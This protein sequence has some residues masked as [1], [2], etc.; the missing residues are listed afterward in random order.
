MSPEALQALA[1]SFLQHGFVV[2]HDALSP[3]ELRVVRHECDAVTARYAAIAGHPLS[4]D[5][6][7]DDEDCE[8]N[9]THEHHGSMEW[10]ST[11]FGCVLEVPGC[12]ECCVDDWDATS[13]GYRRKTCLVTGGAPPATTRKDDAPKNTELKNKP[14]VDEML[15]PNGAL[16]AIATAMLHTFCARQQTLH[17]NPEQHHT[18]SK[19]NQNQN[20]H[21]CLFNDQYIVKPPNSLTARFGWHADSQWCDGSATKRKRADHEIELEIEL[22]MENEI[23]LEIE[24]ENENVTAPYVS[25]WTAL[26]DVD[27]SN[28]CLRVLPYPAFGKEA[29]LNGSTEPGEDGLDGETGSTPGGGAKRYASHEAR[30]SLYRQ[31]PAQLD[32]LSI[33]RWCG[34]STGKQVTLATKAL[35][36]VQVIAMKAGAIL[37]MS[38]RVLHCSGPNAS[39]TLRRAW[40]PQ[41]SRGAV[42]RREGETVKPVAL[43]VAL[44]NI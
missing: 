43:A 8:T 36:D 2:I 29:V 14:S 3:E 13:G 41:F 44:G 27:A 30:A 4:S 1:R 35:R 38:H 18:Q 21:V 16:G 25:L 15:R 22:E 10:L 39:Q 37:C 12:C 17:S 6:E 31:N 26:D 7:E 23:E 20:Q 40:M 42:L 5:V 9:I 34:D 28:G 19:Q 24:N 32:R 33:T 11:N